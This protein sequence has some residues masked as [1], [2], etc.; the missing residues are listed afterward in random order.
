MI[1]EPI[2]WYVSMV[3]IAEFFK[4]D[5]CFPLIAFFFVG[6]EGDSVRTASKQYLSIK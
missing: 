2:R 3:I 4:Y 6:M 1:K 5:N